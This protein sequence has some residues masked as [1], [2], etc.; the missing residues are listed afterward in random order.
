MS[1]SPETD[2]VFLD[3]NLESIP[4]DSQKSAKPLFSIVLNDRRSLHSHRAN[5]RFKMNRSSGIFVDGAVAAEEL[6]P[7]FEKNMSVIFFCLSSSRTVLTSI[8][9]ECNMCFAIVLVLVPLE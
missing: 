9:C 3:G 5:R 1:S 6:F 4:R 8:P 7:L 2:T